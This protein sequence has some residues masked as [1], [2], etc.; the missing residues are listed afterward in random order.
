MDTLPTYDTVRDETE[1]A[2]ARIAD[3]F[4]PGTRMVPRPEQS[5]YGCGSGG[6]MYTGH[7][8]I[9]PAPGFDAAR[10]IEDLPD[11]LGD[12]FVLQDL[13]VETSFP[14]VSFVADAYGGAGIDVS[15]GS[16]DGADVVDV[17]ALSR[18]AQP[19]E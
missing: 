1:A 7:W 12:G 13:G 6:V 3:E 4:P 19:P 15:A 11:K 18:C 14:L 2:I 5:P 10:F 17:I 8:D 16:I 9:Y